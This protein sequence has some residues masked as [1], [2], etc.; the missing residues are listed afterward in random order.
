M[1]PKIQAGEEEWESTISECVF[2]AHSVT[3]TPQSSQEADTVLLSM[4][5]VSKLKYGKMFAPNLS[6]EVAESELGRS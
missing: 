4:L 3:G 2:R 6:Q 1:E 5:L